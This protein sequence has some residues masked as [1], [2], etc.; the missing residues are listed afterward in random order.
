MAPPTPQSW[1]QASPATYSPGA[2]APTGQPFRKSV[3]GAIT[4]LVFAALGAISPFL[5]YVSFDEYA[6]YDEYFD[7]LTVSG[8]DSQEVFDA[9]GETSSGPTLVLVGSLVVLGLAIA[10][11]VNQNNGKRVNKTGFGVG[12]LVSGLVVAGSAGISFSAWDSILNQELLVASQG[13]GLFIGAVS[14]IAAV[15]IGIVMLTVPKVTQGS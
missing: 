1:S 8:W 13:A 4:L 11:I 12:T 10:V 7:G 5:T 14:G 2:P 6:F 3:G 9:Y 15:V